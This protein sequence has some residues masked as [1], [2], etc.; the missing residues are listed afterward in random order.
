MWGLAQGKEGRSQLASEGQLEQLRVVNKEREGTRQASRQSQHP[1][2]AQPSLAA[3]AKTAPAL[4][5]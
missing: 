1:H 4:T 2:P 3:S 5:V